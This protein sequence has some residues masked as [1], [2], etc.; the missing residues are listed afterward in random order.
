MS[1]TEAGGNA[2]IDGLAEPERR[3]LRS[4]RIP[5]EQGAILHR[6]GSPTTHYLFPL[7]GMISLTIPTPAGD[8]VE[9]AL[10]GREGVFGIGSLMGN[11]ATDLQAIAQVEG[12]DGWAALGAVGKQ[13]AS[14][15]PDFDSRTYGASKLSDLV[16][17]A[18]AF[19]VDQPEG[20]TVRIRVK[21]KA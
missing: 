11:P 6:F 7:S 16:R 13:L 19:E 9:V 8:N 1:S 5:L 4:E 20:G 12:E 14:L 10:V 15:A 18:N 3:A 2:L 21:Q 17:K